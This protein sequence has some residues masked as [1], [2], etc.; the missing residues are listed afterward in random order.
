MIAG[1]CDDAG[2]NGTAACTT[3]ANDQASCE[4]QDDG[5]GSNVLCVYKPI[6]QAQPL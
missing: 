1:T 3:H 4:A 5:L 2:N 6:D